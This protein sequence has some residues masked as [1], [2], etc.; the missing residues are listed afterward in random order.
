[1]S[2]AVP[3]FLRIGAV[4]DRVGLSRRT[5][6]DLVADGRFPRPVHPSPHTRA[7]IEAE[8]VEWMEARIAE[9]DAA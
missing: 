9:R 6:L 8:V 5:I 4:I 1:M 7:W 3:R 2:N